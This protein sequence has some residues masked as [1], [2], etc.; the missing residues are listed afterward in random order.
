M[1]GTAVSL[2]TYQFP[3][4]KLIALEDHHPEA[5]PL[6]VEKWVHSICHQCPSGCG[7]LGRVIDEKLVKIEGNPM[8]PVNRGKLCPLGQA[9]LQLLYNPDRLK[10]PL[11]RSGPK[12]S[13]QWQSVGWDEAIET[14]ANQLKKLRRQRSPHLHAVLAKEDESDVG[15]LFDR[16]MNSFGSPNYILNLS[17]KSTRTAQ[18]FMKG[19]YELPAYDL[20]NAN[21]ILS[22]EAPLLEYWHSPM[23]AQKAYG[24]L[25]QERMGVRAKIVQIDTRFSITAA[26]SDQWIPIRPGTHAS[27]ALGIAYVIVKEQLYDRRFIES[28]TFGFEDWVD[29]EGRSQQGFKNFVLRHYQPEQVAETTGIG[30]DTIVYIAKEFA[31]TKPSIAIGG[32]A[33]ND[34]TNATYTEM[35]IH[36][37]NALVGSL[38]T[39][40]GVLHQRGMHFALPRIRKDTIAQDGLSKK[41]ID[42]SRTSRFPSHHAD[43]LCENILEGNPYSLESLWIV[44]ENPVFESVLAQEWKEAL[45][46]VPLVVSFS[47]FLDETSKFADWILPHH[48]Y[49]ERQQLIK[50]PS[51]S[52]TPVVGL[53]QPIVKPL[54]NT[55]HVGD[56]ILQIAR[57]IKGVRKNFPW[58][59]FKSFETHCLKSIFKA[60]R[61]TLFTNSFEEVHIKLLEDRGWW[62]PPHSS[63]QSFQKE[64][65][66]V[67][68]WW[69]PAYP[70]RQWGRVFKTRSHKFEFFSQFL[71]DHLTRKSNR[72]A[73]EDQRYLPH[74][75]AAKIDGDDAGFPFFMNL[76]K[77]LNLGGASAANQPWLQESL[78]PHLVARW[79]SWI[80]VNPKTAEKLGLR[81]KDLVWIESRT[82]RIETQLRFYAGV[83]PDTVNV[84]LGQGHTAVGRWAKMAG[85][86][87]Y[88]IISKQR[89]SLTSVFSHL[90]TRVKIY[91]AS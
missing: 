28:Q 62:I 10:G 39:P 65:V 45:R 9:G 43:A 14:I 44:D 84:P 86:N 40:G 59:D 70:F 56:V 37:L 53:M 34:Y 32:G 64:F 57:R 76:Y 21:F 81:D 78:V 47:S 15:A 41:R 51:V 42:E 27:L 85:V 50:I 66:K 2:L 88:E 63:F 68:G 71:F 55:R 22:F 75:E 89:E 20:E 29:G 73:G 18:L 26:K 11:K 72:D 35:A 49:L 25:R 17:A 83:M 77:P 33:T 48:T 90:T 19:L 46:R 4:R 79:S 1:G 69:D 23:Q 91:K 54:Y 13:N 67:G 61:G 31:R 38:E 24:Y 12:G 16:F 7:I 5:W 74:A 8:H 52:K 30:V 3:L 82:G 6:G 80:E 36:A 60:K 58:K 87:P